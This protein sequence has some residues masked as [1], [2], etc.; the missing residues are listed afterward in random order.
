M[1]FRLTK[2]LWGTKNGGSMATPF[3]TFTF[4]SFLFYVSTCAV[5][6][7]ESHYFVSSQ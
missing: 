1:F 5:V 4:K 6:D 3:E 7:I 2:V